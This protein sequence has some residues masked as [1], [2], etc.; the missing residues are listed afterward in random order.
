MKVLKCFALDFGSR[1]GRVELSLRNLFAVSR[2]A[3]ACL[4]LI[5]LFLRDVGK[6]T[7]YLA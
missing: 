7:I 1:L 6:V 3:S 4:E 2:S 5:G